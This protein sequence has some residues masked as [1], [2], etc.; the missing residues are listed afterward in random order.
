LFDPVL[1]ALNG[2]MDLGDF[3]PPPQLMHGRPVETQHSR[4]LGV[5][6]V[7]VP[8]DDVEPLTGQGPLPLGVQVVL[9]RPAFINRFFAGNSRIIQTRASL[10]RWQNHGRRQRPLPKKQHGEQAELGV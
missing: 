6:F 1:R 8:A 9:H 5:G 4:D 10:P 7:Q 3:I 2:A